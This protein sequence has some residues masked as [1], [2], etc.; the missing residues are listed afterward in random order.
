[1]SKYIS[2]RL[3]KTMD[4]VQ[5]EVR[6]VCC[7]GILAHGACNHNVH[8]NVKTVIEFHFFWLNNLK[9]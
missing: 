8:S 5:L 4:E 3:A 6:T 9:F 1:M 2:N 7:G